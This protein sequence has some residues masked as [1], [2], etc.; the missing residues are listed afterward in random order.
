MT[1]MMK[2]PTTSSNNQNVSLVVFQTKKHEICEVLANKYEWLNRSELTLN[3]SDE[4][5]L[6][7]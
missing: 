6:F 7:F 1:S 2:S 5:K 3:M 4:D